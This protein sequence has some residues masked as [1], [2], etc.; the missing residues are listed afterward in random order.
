[1]IDSEFGFID[2]AKMVG[3][4]ATAAIILGMFSAYATFGWWMLL[5]WLGIPV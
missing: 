3:L 4:L 1:M 5:A 2:I